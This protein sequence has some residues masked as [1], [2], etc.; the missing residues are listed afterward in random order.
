MGYDR[1]ALMSVA[2]VSLAALTLA[3]L[4]LVG[5]KDVA[6]YSTAA[7][8]S[9][10]GSI[11]QGQFVRTGLGPDVQLRMTFDADHVTTSPG[12]ITTS[13]GLLKGAPLHAVP[14]MFADP[15]SMMQFGEGRRRSYL[16]VAE[17]STTDYGQRVNVIVS[18]MDT[19]DVEARLLRWGPNTTPGRPGGARDPGDDMVFGVFPLT[20][21]SGSCGF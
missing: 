3:A 13:D 8:Q 20:R 2:R 9:Y 4:P 21:Q 16:F 18:L 7:G 19:G 12:E 6:S 5:C 17:P 1:A 15:V 11:V 14:P 10:C